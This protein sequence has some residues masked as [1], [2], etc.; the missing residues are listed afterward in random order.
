MTL[1]TLILTNAVLAATLIYAL[2]HFLTHG[3]HAD[4]RHG[5]SRVAELSALPE[6]TRDRIAA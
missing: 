3:V 5:A 2:V 6:R 4:R 1:T